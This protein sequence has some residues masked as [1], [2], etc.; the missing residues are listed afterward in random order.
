MQE[1]QKR[2]RLSN[3]KITLQSF[4]IFFIDIFDRFFPLSFQYNYLNEMNKS[5][6]EKKSTY[7]LF[8]LFFFL[9]NPSI[10]LLFLLKFRKLAKFLIYFPWFNSFFI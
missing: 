10:S 3:E 6:C 2:H 1:I 9:L 8:L 4:D 7:I 5:K